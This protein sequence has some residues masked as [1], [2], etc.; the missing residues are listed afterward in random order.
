MNGLSAARPWRRLAVH[1][2]VWAQGPDLDRA[3]AAGVDPAAS[4]ELL[5]RAD[6]LTDPR[7]SRRFAAALEG[8]VNLADR[9]GALAQTAVVLHPNVI[10]ACRAPLLALAQ[11]LR[12]PEP[13]GVRA[14]AMVSYLTRSG[15]SPLFGTLPI[16]LR[17]YLHDASELVD[18]ARQRSRA[19]NDAGGPGRS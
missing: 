11:R 1:L 4:A 13:V 6:Q 3:L 16:R 10:C 19:V 8:A 14:A 2:R 7:T 17:N 15:D 9:P 12:D 18:A 5:L